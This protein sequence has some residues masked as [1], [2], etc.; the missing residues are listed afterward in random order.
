MPQV[1]QPTRLYADCFARFG[2]LTVKTVPIACTCTIFMSF[3]QC[4]S[5]IACIISK[6]DLIKLILRQA[7]TYVFE[8]QVGNRSE[9]SMFLCLA[10]IA[11]KTSRSVDWPSEKEMGPP[12]SVG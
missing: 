9:A 1:R 7:G 4:A 10:S 3:W 8:L 5:L 12:L 2:S 6:Y 11:L